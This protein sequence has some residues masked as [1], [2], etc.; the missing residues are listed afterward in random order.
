MQEI[1]SLR[2][3]TSA[4]EEEQRRLMSNLKALEGVQIELD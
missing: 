4:A 3:K 2:E 1:N